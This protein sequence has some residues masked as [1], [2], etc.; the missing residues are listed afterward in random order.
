MDA[1]RGDS[2]D[3]IEAEMLV[4][5][6]AL[7]LVKQSECLGDLTAEADLRLG[8]RDACYDGPGSMLTSDDARQGLLLLHAK[9][10]GRWCRKAVDEAVVLLAP[11]FDPLLGPAEVKATW[12]GPSV[13]RGPAKFR[14]PYLT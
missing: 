8:E 3:G 12:Q 10:V 4:G 9:S 13:F 7:Y 11:I 14:K 5:R 1:T 2:K 6:V